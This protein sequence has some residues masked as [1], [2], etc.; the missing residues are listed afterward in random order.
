MPRN[1]RIFF[2]NKTIAYAKGK[3]A[4]HV[5]LHSSGCILSVTVLIRKGS[6]LFWRGCGNQ[7][8]CYLKINKIFAKAVHDASPFFQRHYADPDSDVMMM[9]VSVFAGTSCLELHENR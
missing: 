7:K 9:H 8:R 6:C 1:L 2:R 3:S 5:A 4:G